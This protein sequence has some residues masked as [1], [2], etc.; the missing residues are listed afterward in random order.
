MDLA[1]LMEW[2]RFYQAEPFGAARADHAAAIVAYT[3]ARSAG[4]KRCR[5]D[6]FLPKTKP[7]GPPAVARQKQMIRAAL[8]AAGGAISVR[9]V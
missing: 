9:K 5:F 6:D 8:L 4:N 2:R 3:V 1:E 7:D